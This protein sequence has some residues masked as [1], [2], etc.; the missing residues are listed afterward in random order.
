M[1]IRQLALRANVVS[2]LEQ[3]VKKEHVVSYIYFRIGG[4][5]VDLYDRKDLVEMLGLQE[6]HSL[7]RS[8]IVFQDGFDRCENFETLESFAAYVFPALMKQKSAAAAEYRQAFPEIDTLAS[9]P[10]DT[11]LEEKQP[12]ASPS[13]SIG[14]FRRHFTRSVA[15]IRKAVLAQKIP[16]RRYNGVEVVEKK[17]LF[18]RLPQIL[19]DYLDQHLQ[20]IRGA[21]KFYVR[22]G[23]TNFSCRTPSPA[24]ALRLKTKY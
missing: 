17:P 18:D 8:R 22:T 20:V 15:D 1:W 6:D 4:A 23:T 16:L 7:P 2:F 13:F 24:A 10:R 21:N 14:V 9:L 11:T 3:K 19:A 5:A 12:P